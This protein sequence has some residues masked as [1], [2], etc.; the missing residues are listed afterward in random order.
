MKPPIFRRYRS[1]VLPA[2][3]GPLS[4]RRS[5]HGGPVFFPSS[6]PLPEPAAPAPSAYTPSVSQGQLDQPASD[7]ARPRPEQQERQTS[8]VA[9][10]RAAAPRNTCLRRN[11]HRSAATWRTRKRRCPQEAPEEKPEDGCEPSSR[12]SGDERGESPDRKG[13]DVGLRGSWRL[14]PEASIPI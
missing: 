1:A 3:R 11:R 14:H 6:R 8:R 10:L 2:C 13:R 9:R 5:R 12:A 7:K 4:S